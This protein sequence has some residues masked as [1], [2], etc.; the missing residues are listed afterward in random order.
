MTVRS[1]SART[2]P[3]AASDPVPYGS[4]WIDRFT[5]WVDR[6]PGPAWAFYA[7]LA[8][9]WLLAAHF[10][11]GRRSNGSLPFGNL[12][13]FPLAAPIWPVL[14]IALIH[15][16]DRQASRA[17]AVF[18]PAMEVSDGEYASL[19]RALTT[20][21]AR[22]VLI[23]TLLGST[24]GVGG[25]LLLPDQL[26]AFLFTSPLD[27]GFIIAVSLFGYG[28]SAALIFHTFRRVRLV[29]RI[30]AGATRVNLFRLDPVYAL[31]GL[32]A[33]SAIGWAIA[34]Y[35]T[36]ITVSLAL[37]VALGN[38]LVTI[39]VAVGLVLIVAAFIWPL[40]GIHLRMAKEKARLQAEANGRLEAAIAEL[41]RR[42]DEV[43][44]SGMDDLN[45]AMASLVIERDAI[46]KIPTWPWTPGTLRGFLSALLIPLVLFVIQRVLDRAAIF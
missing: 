25:L 35:A 5:D 3:R 30:Y 44:L 17:L 37:P 10:A 28:P 18:R 26:K 24:L 42:I 43:Q 36:L 27:S 23:A 2:Q 29:S 31:S 9:V 45:K 20:M 38:P 6:L 7:G 15:Y 46:A 13:W 12:A 22:P 8:L 40:W 41:H 1:E 21:P 32:T 14:P 34:L 39:P 33:R 11:L 4:S 16:L 19:E